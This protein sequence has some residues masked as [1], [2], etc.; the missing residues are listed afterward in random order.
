M[1]KDLLG[2]CLSENETEEDEEEGP[3]LDFG[4]VSVGATKS[5]L[6]TLLNP[7]SVSIELNDIKWTM[8]DTNVTV[9]GGKFRFD[10]GKLMDI[11]E[12]VMSDYIDVADAYDGFGSPDYEVY[13]VTPSRSKV[14]VAANSFVILK[15]SIRAPVEGQMMGGHLIMKSKYEVSFSFSRRFC[16]LEKSS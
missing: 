4:Y 6:L 15:V 13:P 3:H 16:I 12:N 10:G 1:D 8:E 11:A 5:L 7:N 14:S 2:N 9:V